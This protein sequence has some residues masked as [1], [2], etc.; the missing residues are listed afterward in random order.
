MS[1]LILG[2]GGLGTAL[3][4]ELVD[5]GEEWILAGRQSPRGLDPARYF[6]LQEVDPLSFEA[7]FTLYDRESLPT[8]VINTIGLLYDLNHM[9]ERRVEEVEPGW[10]NE[11]LQAN[12]WPH[13]A[14]GANLSQLM[15]P[16]TSLWLCSVSDLAGSL[17]STGRLSEPGRY[18]YRMSKAALNMG[19]RILA[20]EW[21]SRFP[22]AGVVTV[23]PGLMDTPM[24]QPFLHERD[25]ALLQDPALVAPRLLDLIGT[26]T[27]SQSGSFLDLQGQPLPW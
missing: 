8:V 20:V 26:L 5:R 17:G 9:P 14:L 2:S 24:Q 1:Y 12:A 4:H 22:G 21:A 27:P 13:L 10:L 15:G 19:A 25:P 23:H 18:S 16:A 11:S 6:P 3:A 7:L